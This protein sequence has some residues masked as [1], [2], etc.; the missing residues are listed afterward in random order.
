MSHLRLRRRDEACSTRALQQARRI[1]PGRLE[2]HRPLQ[3][4]LRPAH[5][6]PLLQ[7]WRPPYQ[8]RHQGSRLLR[9]R[10]RPPAHRHRQMAVGQH[11]LLAARRLHMGCLREPEPEDARRHRPLQRPPAPR[12]LHQHAHQRRSRAVSG[13]AR[14]EHQVCQPAGRRPRQVLRYGSRHE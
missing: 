1:C 3:A 2:H 6:R 11:H 9:H 8:R 14:P 7:Q 5:R 12:V 4:R 10:R 13:T